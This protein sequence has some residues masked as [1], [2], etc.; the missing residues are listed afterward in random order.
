MMVGSEFVYF[1][2]HMYCL[3]DKIEDIDIWFPKLN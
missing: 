1:F 3:R 2:V